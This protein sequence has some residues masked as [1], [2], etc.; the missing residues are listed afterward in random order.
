[1]SVNN[2]FRSLR[3]RLYPVTM[4][5]LSVQELSHEVSVMAKMSTDFLCSISLIWSSLFVIDLVLSCIIFSPLFGRL[6]AVIGSKS[7]SI[8]VLVRKPFSMFPKK[9]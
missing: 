7:S 6:N 4:S 3:N 2:V 5:S 8:V 1:M 9:Q